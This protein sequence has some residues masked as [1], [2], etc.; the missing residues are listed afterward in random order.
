MSAAASTPHVRHRLLVSALAILVVLAALPQTACSVFPAAAKQIQ[1]LIEGDDLAAQEAGQSGTVALAATVSC[2][3]RTARAAADG[4]YSLSLPPASQYT[5]TATAPGYLP[6]SATIAG[7][8]ADTVTSLNFAGSPWGLNCDTAEQPQSIQC[9]A[10]RLVPGTLTGRA[11]WRGTRQAAARVAITCWNP[12]A[13][14]ASPDYPAFG[15]GPQ[16][17]TASTDARGAYTLDSLPAGPYDCTAGSDIQ[18]H[19]V[20]V[21]SSHSATLDV[22]VCHTT[23]PPVRYHQGQVLHTLTAYLIFWLPGGHTYD[24]M[25]SASYEGLIARYFR[26]VGGTRFN[27]ILTQYWDYNGPLQNR[28]TLGGT[29]VD[30]Q[31]YPH[32]GTLADPLLDPDIEGEIGRVIA[33]RGWETQPGDEYYIFTGYGTEVC[34][35]QDKSACTYTTHGEF[36]GYHSFGDLNPAQPGVR[37]TYAMIPDIRGCVGDL[38]D[39]PTAS[40]NGDR[41]A[42][43]VISVVSHEQ[44]ETMTD[45]GAHSW[46]EADLEE[47]EIGDLCVNAYGTIRSDGSNVTLGHGDEYVIQQEWSDLAGGCTFG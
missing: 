15:T 22:P 2:D 8:S 46:Y 42:D 28:V 20:K 31:P 32:A 47:G 13:Y 7:P 11:T 45:P 12:V 6:A 35:T 4:T 14:Q 23:C 27:G 29:Y 3:G 9:P 16:L 37:L 21:A 17:Y 26:D 1:G 39:R 30:T 43:T 34:Y 5:C 36:C 41:V 38:G 33:A 40:P 25:G 18:I 19:A 44:F 24:N 10:L